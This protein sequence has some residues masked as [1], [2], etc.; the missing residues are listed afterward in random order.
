[1][2]SV[3][4]GSSNGHCLDDGMDLGGERPPLAAE[5]ENLGGERMGMGFPSRTSLLI[6][7]NPFCA[8]ILSITFLLN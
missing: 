1:M 3:V 4:V 5:N 6:S 2:L 8:H 7:I